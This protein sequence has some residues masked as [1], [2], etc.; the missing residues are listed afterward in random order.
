[1]A[2]DCTQMD[3]TL[4]ASLFRRKPDGFAS[5]TEIKTFEMHG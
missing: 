5:D 3:E 4:R 1:M 2:R